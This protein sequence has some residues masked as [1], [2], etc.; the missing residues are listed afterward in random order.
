MDPS[1][2]AI[3]SI[4]LICIAELIIWLLLCLAVTAIVAVVQL[5]NKK[6]VN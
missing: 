2:V 5:T 6:F 1:R 3:I 4:Y